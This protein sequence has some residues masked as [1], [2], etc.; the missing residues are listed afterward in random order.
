MDV[1]KQGKTSTCCDGQPILKIYQN[2]ERMKCGSQPS[3]INSRSW[4]THRIG[5]EM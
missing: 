2:D 5:P 3:Y 1:G 4:A